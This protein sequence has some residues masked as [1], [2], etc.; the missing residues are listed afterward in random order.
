MKEFKIL[1]LNPGRVITC[2]YKRIHP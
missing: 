1:P 2:T